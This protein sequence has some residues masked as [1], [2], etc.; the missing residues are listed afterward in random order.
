VNTRLVT[1]VFPGVSVA[2]SGEVFIGTVTAASGKPLIVR[3]V[4]VKLFDTATSNPD[5]THR[6]RALS[7]A[8]TGASSPAG[9]AC[10]RTNSASLS[11][12]SQIGAFS[13]AP[14]SIGI[15]DAAVLPYTS[16]MLKPYAY[17]EMTIASGESLG[18]SVERNSATGSATAFC[19]VRVYEP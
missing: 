8:G 9:T 17:G 14:T 6:I 13:V 11:S 1:Y 18:V 16:L 19:V 10:D 7:T 15:Q 3:D 12:S 2:A 4:F 5:V